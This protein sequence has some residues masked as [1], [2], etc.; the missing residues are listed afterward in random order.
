MKLSYTT[1]CSIIEVYRKFQRIEKI[2]HKLRKRKLKLVKAQKIKKEEELKQEFL[3]KDEENPL[4]SEEN[5]LKNEEEP[6]LKLEKDFKTNES[7]IKHQFCKKEE[8]LK[9]EYKKN[10]YQE[11]IS[12]QSASVHY[13]KPENRGISPSFENYYPVNNLNLNLPSRLNPLF[14]LLPNALPAPFSTPNPFLPLNFRA[15]L[16]FQNR[17]PYYC[18]YT[19][20]Q[21]FFSFPHM[22]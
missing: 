22:N 21:G 13:Y 4:K 19:R 10:E 7:V 9:I 12:P 5:P 14:C 15:S 20:N 6:Q 11:P 16:N 3:L 1:T 8:C 18:S 17:D 2:P